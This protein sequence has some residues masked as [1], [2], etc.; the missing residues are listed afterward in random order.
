MAAALTDLLPSQA[1]AVNTVVG[2]ALAQTDK[3]GAQ[4][5]AWFE[6]V[7]DRTSERFKLH[8]R[9]ATAL[10]ATVLVFGLQID[11]MDIIRQL[12]NKDVREGVIRL[13]EPALR[14][15]DEVTGYTQNRANLATDVLKG[16]ATD[17][18]FQSLL[19]TATPPAELELRS[20]G[21]NWLQGQLK[22]N[23]RLPE[24][25]KAFDDRYETAAKTLSDKFNAEAGKTKDLLDKTGLLVIP[26]KRLPVGD[27]K[28]GKWA[29]LL[30]TAFFLSLGA[31]FWYNALR[32]LSDLRPI[33][34]RKV[35][36]EPA[37]ALQ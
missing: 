19:G 16:M 14:M 26:A 5:Q 34:A 15:Y 1:A 29:G 36:G 13:Y 23:Q 28:L 9:W 10:I 30:A 33:V 8:S 31:P 32:K 17:P 7:M 18:A 4:I 11:S 20:E 35:E 25:Q 12:S 3:L 6:T 27:W 37:K 21:R 24:A 22:G 2:Q